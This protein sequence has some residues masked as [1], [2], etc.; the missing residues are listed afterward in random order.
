MAQRTTFVEGVEGHVVSKLGKA[1]RV[2]VLLRLFF[3]QRP[4]RRALTYK[5]GDLAGRH[6]EAARV[7]GGVGHVGAEVHVVDDPVHAPLVG[8][9]VHGHGGGVLDGVLRVHAGGC[10]CR[11]VG[12]CVCRCGESGTLA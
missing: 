10:A 11:C 6:G 9:V 8:V 4:R 5:S 2:V 12:V 3:F 1:G 7:V